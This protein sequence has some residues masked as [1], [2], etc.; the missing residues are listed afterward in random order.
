MKAKTQLK[1]SNR[2]RALKEEE[3][4]VYWASAGIT[5]SCEC[6][7]RITFE[8]PGEHKC[9]CGIRYKCTLSLLA[10]KDNEDD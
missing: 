3:V 5:F 4:D 2:Y 7:N 8:D 9:S 6:G 10:K 1:L